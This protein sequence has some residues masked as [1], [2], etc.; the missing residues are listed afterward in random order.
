V[1][2]NDTEGRNGLY[3]ALFHL[4][5]VRCRRKKSSRSLSHLLMSFLYIQ[6]IQV[7]VKMADEQIVLCDALFLPI[8]RDIGLNGRLNNLESALVAICSDLYRVVSSEIYSNLSGNF[9]KF[10]EEFFFPMSINYFQVQD[11]VK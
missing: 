6:L 5:R 8:L 9:R 7:P 2:L 1:I 3:F 11:A 4:I 10:L